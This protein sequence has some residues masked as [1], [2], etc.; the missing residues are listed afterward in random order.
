[1]AD[2]VRLAIEVMLCSRWDS[3]I[4]R[5]AWGMTYT[6]VGVCVRKEVGVLGSGLDRG[7]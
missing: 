4:L 1:M 7:M 5:G 2:W 6:W 3:D